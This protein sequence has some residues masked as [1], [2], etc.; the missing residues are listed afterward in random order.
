MR[1]YRSGGRV[2][3]YQGGGLAQVSAP[4][5]G[6]PPWV[7]PAGYMEPEGYQAGGRTQPW[8]GA[9]R[10]QWRGAAGN[11]ARRQ[12]LRRAYNSYTP[13]QQAGYTGRVGYQKGP[14]APAPQAAGRAGMMADAQQQ[15]QALQQRAGMAGA[16]ADYQQGLA[17]QRGARP[18]VYGDAPQPGMAYPGGTPGF[19][20]PGGPGGG[21]G[22]LPGE[23]DMGGYRKSIYDRPFGNMRDQLGRQGTP[24]TPGGAGR[25]TPQQQQA[26]RGAAGNPA[27]RGAMG[28][29]HQQRQ[30]LGRQPGAGGITGG[31][32][33][34][35]NMQGYLQKQRMMNRPPSNV[36]GGVNRVGQ[37]DQQGGLSRA[38]QRGT[39][40]RPM[41]RRGGF[42]GG[43]M[44]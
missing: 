38:M 6:V 44:Q 7:E 13:E 1:R 8:S 30:A 28:Q 33:V 41:S 20:G 12:N 24:P 34:P 19:Y 21:Q 11:P 18:P 4:R 37:Q 15:Q 22:I 3:G 31:A 23:G 26:W 16:Q 29:Q 5:G 9:Q 32:R 17:A 10:Q 42:P 40:R 25:W 2:R 27:L 14:Q 35:P 36:G 39:G 43:G